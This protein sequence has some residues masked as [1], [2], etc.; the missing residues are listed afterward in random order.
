MDLIQFFKCLSDLNR[1]TCLCLIQKAG[2][3][4]VG[5]IQVALNQE[6]PKVSQYLA[7]LRK[8]GIL[9]SERR[10]KWV[11]Y[12]FSADLPN[13]ALKVITCSIEN[14]PALF[15]DAIALFDSVHSRNACDNESNNNADK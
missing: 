4:C 3:A 6:Q 5:E 12:R 10:G 7:Q 8:C 14:N 11:Y 15:A 13:W 1:L 2:E 9:Q